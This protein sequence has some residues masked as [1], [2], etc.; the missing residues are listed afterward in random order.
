MAA[1]IPAKT[2]AEHQI[3]TMDGAGSSGMHHFSEWLVFDSYNQAYTMDLPQLIN[4]RWL[5][6]SGDSDF[7]YPTPARERISIMFKAALYL[8]AAIW[9]G[10]LM[11]GLSLWLFTRFENSRNAR[12]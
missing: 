10:S 4:A 11:V 5:S 3:E 12:T 7:G 1:A 8:I 2:P 9:G 6:H